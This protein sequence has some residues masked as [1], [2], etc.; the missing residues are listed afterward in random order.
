M[1]GK[2]ILMHA[3]N[4]KNEAAWTPE[5]P[6]TSSQV[7]WPRVADNTSVSHTIDECFYDGGR[8]LFC[9]TY[10]YTRDNDETVE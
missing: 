6:P 8:M 10:T 4:V 3:S 5:H 2:K 7:V 1:E 9:S